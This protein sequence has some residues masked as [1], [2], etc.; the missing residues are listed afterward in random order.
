MS[1]ENST[2]DIELVKDSLEYYDKNTEKYK[3]KLDEITYVKFKQTNND[4]EHNYI[5]LYN[6]DKKELYKSKYEYIGLYEPQINIWTW[7][8]AVPTFSKKNTVIIRKLLMYGTELDPSSHFLKSELITSRFRIN[9]QVQL[10]IH[11]SIASYIA[12]KPYVL[13]M[14]QYKN[15]LIEDDL[16]NIKIP[17]YFRENSEENNVEEYTEYYIFLLDEI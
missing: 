15:P 11:A 6:E 4:H 2:P 14:K 12:K 9:N 17:Q 16:I 3:K 1:Q 10:D 8:W 13:R 7:A 5:Y